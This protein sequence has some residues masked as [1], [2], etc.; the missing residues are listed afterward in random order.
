QRYIAVRSEQGRSLFGRAPR[1][2]RPAAARTPATPSPAPLAP[3]SRS[4]VPAARRSARPRS[5]RWLPPAAPPPPRARLQSGNS[6]D[7]ARFHVP[8]LWPAFVNAGRAVVAIGAMELFWIAS[9]W[10]NGA[11]AITFT[12]I[13]VTLLAPTADAAY[14]FA[15]RFAFG[16]V[17]GSVGAAIIGFAVLPKVETFIG[18]SIVIGLYLV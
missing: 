10:P 15:Y 12:A 18:F 13:V 9:A 6:S 4:L 17:L 1:S 2:G 14:A 3:G 16:V 5:G 8:D 7:R 11:F